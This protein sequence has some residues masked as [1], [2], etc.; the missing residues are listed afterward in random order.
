[1]EETQKDSQLTHFNQ[2]S[3]KTSCFNNSSSEIEDSDPEDDGLKEIEIMADAS[4]EEVLVK[5]TLILIL[6]FLNYLNNY[7]TFYFE[8]QAIF[9]Q[10]YN[11]FINFTF[12]IN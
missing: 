4:D 9:L 3:E 10:F 1:M 8:I 2:K 12:F 7:L 6:Y 11:F 5:K